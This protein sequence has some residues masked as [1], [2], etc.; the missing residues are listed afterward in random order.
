M[1]TFWDHSTVL[2]GI[3]R[4]ITNS[5]KEKRIWLPSRT[6]MGRR[7]TTPR[8]MLMTARK[9]R[10]LLLPALR[11]LTDLL[12]DQDGPAHVLRRDAPL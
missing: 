10:K 4:R 12:E 7:L 2:S 11:V 8:F 6:G 3:F 9:K 5:K 1:P